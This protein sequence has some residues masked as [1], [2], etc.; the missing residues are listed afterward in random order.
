MHPGGHSSEPESM[1]IEMPLLIYHHLITAFHLLN[2][3]GNCA[4][5]LV[6][7]GRQDCQLLTNFPNNLAYYLVFQEMSVI[8]VWL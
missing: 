8:W 1:V 5:C 2:F 7:Q 4:C 3:I 6:L